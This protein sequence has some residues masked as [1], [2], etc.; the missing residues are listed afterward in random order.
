VDELV[1]DTGMNRGSAKYYLDAYWAMRKGAL[2]KRT[3]NLIAI[4]YYLEQIFRDFGDIAL[5]NAIDSVMAHIEY[6]K[7]SSGQDLLSLRKICDEFRMTCAA[8][9]TTAS[10]DD[11]MASFEAEV[12][13]LLDAPSSE[14]ASLLPEAGHKPARIV[15]TITTFVRNA[16]VVAEVLRRANGL[17]ENCCQPAPFK[18]SSDGRPFLEVHHRKRLADDGEDTVGNAMAVCPNCHREMHYG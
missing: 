13:R 6:Y 5:K 7:L 12:D 8:E 9:S 2:F 14:R 16:A 4:R 18:R 15:S 11:R 17:C 1:R 10:F 3:I